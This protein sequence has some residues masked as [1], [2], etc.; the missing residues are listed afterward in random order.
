MPQRTFNVRAAKG[1]RIRDAKSLRG[2]FCWPDFPA[3]ELQQRLIQPAPAAAPP[4]LAARCAGGI[5][6]LDL[7]LMRL[8]T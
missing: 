2:N 3:E 1:E 5:R 8:T 4:M 7:Q 6:T